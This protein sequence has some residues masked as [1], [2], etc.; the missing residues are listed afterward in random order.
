LDPEERRNFYGLLP[1][2]V[3]VHPDGTPEVLLS[4]PAAGGEADTKV[5]TGATLRGIVLG[6]RHPRS[7]SL[8]AII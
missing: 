1:L 6:H 3:L 4:A 7:G 2:Q 8:A 5:R